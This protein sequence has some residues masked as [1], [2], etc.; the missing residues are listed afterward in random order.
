M[1]GERVLNGDICE[2][3]WLELGEGDGYPRQCEW[4]KANIKDDNDE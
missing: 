1:I 2:L 3:C 4:C